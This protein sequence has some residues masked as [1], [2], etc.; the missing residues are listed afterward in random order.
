MIFYSNWIPAT[1]RYYWVLKGMEIEKSEKLFKGKIGG[2][3]D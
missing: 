2:R 3:V 1:S